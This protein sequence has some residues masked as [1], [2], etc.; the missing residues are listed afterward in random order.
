MSSAEKY[1]SGYYEARIQVQFPFAIRRTA[2]KTKGAAGKTISHSGI[3]SR[4][5]NKLI[6][7][8]PVQR[9]TFKHRTAQDPLSIIMDIRKGQI[10]RFIHTVRKRR[11]AVNQF[12]FLFT[13]LSSRFRICR[14][15]KFNHY[16]FIRRTRATF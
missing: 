2:K 6:I 8:A 15:F 10:S 9:T 7:P 13:Y 4:T 16:Y 3:L 5:D 14:R 12:Q 1:L 11:L